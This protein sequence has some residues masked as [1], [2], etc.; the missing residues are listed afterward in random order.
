MTRLRQKEL[1][2]TNGVKCAIIFSLTSIIISIFTLASYTNSSL[3]LDYMNIIVGILSLLVTTL[4]GWQV[5]NAIEM[6]G[7]IRDFDNLKMRLEDYNQEQID[8]I[9]RINNLNEAH[10]L[11]AKS[12]QNENGLLNI[13]Y[14]D[15]AQAALLFL[16]A[17][18]NSKDSEFIIAISNLEH[19][20]DLSNYVSTDKLGDFTEIHD[21]LENIY[22]SIIQY[23][24]SEKDVVEQLIS[25]INNCRHKRHILS[26]QTKF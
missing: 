15:M 5:Y 18:R 16:E 13:R 26:K 24:T 21:E 25:D 14:K 9:L 12:K 20:L 1:N 11:F 4:I 10:R 17:G 7:V 22:N 3:S 6:R 19:I 23:L 8:K 2:K